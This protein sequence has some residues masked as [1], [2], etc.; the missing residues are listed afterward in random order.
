MRQRERLGVIRITKQADY[1]LV[2]LALFAKGHGG[3]SFT[4][5]DLAAETHLGLP[6]V[7]KILK[8][9]VHAGLLV[10]HRGVKGGYSLARHPA[11]I[12][13]YDVIAALD[14]PISLTECSTEGSD[15]QV[16]TWC[17]VRKPWARINEAIKDALQ[18]VSLAEMTCPVADPVCAFSGEKGSR[19]ANV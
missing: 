10:S 18:R 14:G 7:A 11:E 3:R 15:C 13:V 5:K 9:L 16:E 6:M 17:Q 1:G 4:T 19:I 12:T 8:L 2:L